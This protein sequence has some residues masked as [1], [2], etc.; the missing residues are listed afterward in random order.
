MQEAKLAKEKMNGRLTC[1]RPLVVRLASEKLFEETTHNPHKA[2]IGCEANKSSL[3]SS[4]LGQMSRSGKIAAIKKKLKALEEESCS[5]K[6]PR[7]SDS[8]SCSCDRVN[9]TSF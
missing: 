8:T 5:A 9:K 4:S 7:Q 2:V 1:G 3:A 6:K